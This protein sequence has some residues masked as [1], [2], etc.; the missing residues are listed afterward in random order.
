MAREVGQET[1]P[2]RGQGVAFEVGQ[3]TGE[4]VVDPDEGGRTRGEG[5]GEPTGKF[6]PAPSPARGRG[7]NFT[8]RFRR[9]LRGVNPQAGEPGLGGSRPRIVD[10]EVSAEARAT[11]H[12]RKGAVGGRRGKRDF[13]LRRG[14]V[15]VC[16]LKMN[17]IRATGRLLILGLLAGLGGTLPAAER[18]GVALYGGNGHQLR[19]EK[20]RDHPHARLI[21]VSGVRQTNPPDGVKVVAGLDALLADPAV[22]LVVLCSPRRADQARDAIRCLEAGRHVYAEKPSALTEVELDAIL[23][24]ARRSGRQ[25]REMAGTVFAAPY[26]A[27]RRHV[28]AGEIGEVVQVL[29]QK[30]YRYGAARPQDEALDGGLFLQAGIHGARMV[31]HAG[32]VRMTELTV[33]ETG[34]GKPAAEQ[35][36]GKLAA[37]AQGRLEN[38]GLVTLVINYLNP[39]APGLPHGNETLRIFG[40]RGFIESVDGG[41]R[42]RLV[43]KEGVTE[44]LDRTPGPDYFDAFA[45]Q[46]VTGAPMPLTSEEEL[47]PLRVMLRAKE[48]LRAAAPR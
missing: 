25:F 32:G 3:G 30:S 8:R 47:H 9:V 29:V 41:A 7:R 42:T 18:I 48:R 35:G 11:R 16:L 20:F 26:A 40:T 31:E 22:G 43:R 44:P 2:I 45:A 46:L 1:V 39:G 17:L 4:A 33:D 14:I 6:A 28:Q 27:I 21:A 19:F 34:F 15:A 36:E 24:A 10:P 23:A 38:G 5:V 37:I 13:A 12:A